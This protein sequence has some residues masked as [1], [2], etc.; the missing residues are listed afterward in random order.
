[1]F[2][3]EFSSYWVTY[4]ADGTR[5][6]LLLTR[7]GVFVIN[8]DFEFQRVEQRFPSSFKMDNVTANPGIPHHM[9]LLD[10]EM[11]I[12]HDKD[13]DRYIRKYLVYDLV[14]HQGQSW[15]ELPWKQRF[16]ALQEIVKLRDSEIDKIQKKQWP[17]EY[18]YEEEPFRVEAK[19]FWFMGQAE[20]IVKIIPTLRHECDGF[21]FQA[22]EDKYQVGTHEELLKWKYPHLNSVDFRYRH[23]SS[24]SPLICSL[25]SGS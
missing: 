13:R 25:W 24:P 21:I 6:M 5:Y 11:V 19:M 22:Y 9:T 18:R 1:M 2:D 20:G 17:F 3:V 4:K 12:D 16:A 23:N 7:C 8:R 10:G 15:M 14:L